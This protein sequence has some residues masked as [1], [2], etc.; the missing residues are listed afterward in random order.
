[1]SLNV[2][3]RLADPAARLPM[4]N[5]PGAFVSGE[6]MICLI[7]PFWSQCLADGS[8]VRVDESPEPITA[9]KPVAARGPDVSDRKGA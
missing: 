2:K 9:T 5:N 8:L 3:V 4:P 7:D 6:I 1:M